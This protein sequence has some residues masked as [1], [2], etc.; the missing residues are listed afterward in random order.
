MNITFSFTSS[1]RVRSNTRLSL[2][3]GLVDTTTAIPLL[4]K[5]SWWNPSNTRLC[6]HKTTTLTAL[7][8][9]CFFWSTS[10][11]VWYNS[12]APLCWHY[13]WRLKSLQELGL[14]ATVTRRT[15]V[16]WCHP[17]SVFTAQNECT[18][19]SLSARQLLTSHCSWDC[20]CTYSICIT[21]TTHPLT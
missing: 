19:S 3:K 10:H 6:R 9:Y 20:F 21:P 18:F 4:S 2:K 13:C 15:P 12:K 5:P 17:P 11:R 7:S 8:H 14:S 1:R 16:F